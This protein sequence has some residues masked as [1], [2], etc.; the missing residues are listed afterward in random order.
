MT[1]PRVAP[2]HSA[3][4]AAP[5]SRAGVLLAAGFGLGYLP[6]APGAWGS[7]ASVLLFVPLYYGLEGPTL[8]LAYFFLLVGLALTAL[9]ST[10]RA[11][12]HWKSADPRA[13]VIDEILGQW[14]THA[15]LMAATALG[16]PA[17][18]AGPRWQYLLTGFILFRVFDV[19]K[20]FP[21]RRSER[22]PGAY[23]VVLDDVLAGF[24]AGAGLLVLIW[25]KWLP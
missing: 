7:L 4:P 5:P 8:Q 9:W 16:L 13:I 20:P 15:G 24:Y 19:V 11:L 18:V 21:I 1:I 12:E 10:E 2:E 25:T 23:G 17:A 6:L 14:V 3:E 22:L